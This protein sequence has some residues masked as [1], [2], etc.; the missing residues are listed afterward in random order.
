MCLTVSI[1]PRLL[2]F[3][4]F[5]RLPFEQYQNVH[6]VSLF[7]MMMQPKYVRLIVSSNK[8]VQPTVRS[9]GSF[10]LKTMSSSI[11]RQDS[12][13]AESLNKAGSPSSALPSS[14]LDLS[15]TSTKSTISIPMKL[16]ETNDG[17]NPEQISAASQT[18]SSSSMDTPATEICPA[19]SVSSMDR[20][21][22]FDFVLLLSSH[23]SISKKLVH[24][25]R[26]GKDVKKA[27]VIRYSRHKQP[28]IRSTNSDGGKRQKEEISTSW[29]TTSSH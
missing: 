16:E 8:N 27:N 11:Y 13:P 6:L 21:K 14:P 22:S 26:K 17:T 12:L 3:S 4:F 1:P 29:I 9:V 15:S 19:E 25:I 5:Y 28:C 18:A 20:C 7:Q 2:S 10:Q 23:R 24:L